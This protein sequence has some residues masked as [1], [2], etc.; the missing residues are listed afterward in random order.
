MYR[1]GF[2][3]K[4][5]KSGAIN[6]ITCFCEKVLKFNNYDKIVKCYRC[7]SIFEIKNNEAIFKK[8]LLEGFNE[9]NYT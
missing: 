1:N 3:M 2:A 4:I 5:K 6:T 9:T 8:N 7:G